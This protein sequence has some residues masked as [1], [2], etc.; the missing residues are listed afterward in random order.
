MLSVVVSVYNEEDNIRPLVDRISRSLQGYPYEIIFV[1][2]GS[3]DKTLKALLKIKKSLKELR[4]IGFENNQG[5]TIAMERGMKNAKGDII[6]TMDG[7]LQNFPEDIPRLISRLERGFDVVCG[8]RWRRK[9]KLLTKNIPSLLSNALV[10]LIGGVKINDSGCSLRAYRRKCLHELHMFGEMHRFIPL[11]LAQKGFR[12]SQIKV[13]HAKRIFGKTKYGNERYLR[14]FI[15]LMFVFFLSR[16][17][18][19][20]LHFFGALGLLTI[21]AGVFFFFADLFYLTV[22]LG[23]PFLELDLGPIFMVAFLAIFFGL[24]FLVLGFMSEMIFYS[25]NRN[26]KE[27]EY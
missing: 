25:Y 27:K 22:V 14:G 3:T 23:L 1:D 21:G 8:W 12:I 16:F 17:V 10:R 11:I 6:V 4:V 7:D 2:D 15:D 13:R 20:P 19:R 26:I 24:N 18:R 5:Q 9:D